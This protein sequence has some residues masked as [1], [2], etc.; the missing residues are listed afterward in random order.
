M[1]YL[2]LFFVLLSVTGMGQ[3]MPVD[4]EI[5][6]LKVQLDK[7]ETLKTLF[8]TNRCNVQHMGNTVPLVA[9]ALRSKG[10]CMV[11]GPNIP[12]QYLANHEAPHPGKIAGEVDKVFRR[13]G[14]GQSVIV[15]EADLGSSPGSKTLDTL[16][17]TVRDPVLLDGGELPLYSIHKYQLSVPK[18]GEHVEVRGEGPFK[19]DVVVSCN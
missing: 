15:F 7:L 3:T 6:K 16:Q 10:L 5:T 18:S 17:I 4:H 19:S 2:S 11:I 12:G 8:Q 14:A 9:G 13:R 1:R